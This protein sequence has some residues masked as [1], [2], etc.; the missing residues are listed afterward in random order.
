MGDQHDGGAQAVAQ[1]AQQGQDLRLHGDV[2]RRRRLVGDEKLRIAGQRH[3]DHH[4]L[5]HPAGELVRVLLGASLGVRDLDEAK[6]LQGA[7][8][9]LRPTDMAVKHEGFGDL[10][11]DLQDRI[12][13]RHRLLKDHGDIVAADGAHL[14]FAE[15]H[16][17]AAEQPDAAADDFPRG[18]RNEPHDRQGRDAL[19]ATGFADDAEHLAGMHRI[20]D[21]VDGAHDPVAIVEIGSQIVD[22]QQRVATRHGGDIH[23]A[24]L[25]V[26][27]SAKARIE[28]V[29]QTVADEVDE[30]HRRP[31]KEARIEHDP[32]GLL[33]HVAALGDHAAPGRRGRRDAETEEAE[34]GFRQDRGRADEARLDDQRRDGVRQDML[35]QQL[36]EPRADGA[37]GVDIGL[38]PHAQHH[39]TDEA[40]DARHLRQRD[41][42]DDGC[43]ARPHDRDQCDGEQDAG[44]RHHA[45]H[46]A[47]QD[48]VGDAVEA[49]NQ[50][51]RDD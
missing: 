25:H 32:E 10:V 17:V 35:E 46:H 15:G 28:H 43:H 47:H 11:A 42:D 33:D 1:V 37:S 36:G 16:E 49:G 12:E 3:R 51:D 30:K 18:P 39:R 5:P 9:R 34:I 2:E 26:T 6:H 24:E 27:G 14:G 38:F 8:A 45:V 23:F 4:A 29:A 22:L 50:S 40:R 41:R 31:E 48:R 21:V 7:L 13:R 20:G 44:D 19:A